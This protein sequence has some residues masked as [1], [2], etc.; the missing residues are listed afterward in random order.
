MPG[1]DRTSSGL[2]APRWGSR[3]APP[4]IISFANNRHFQEALAVAGVV[5]G[6]GM[7][8]SGVG[9]KLGDGWADGDAVKADVA[10]RRIQ[11][12]YGSRDRF[13]KL[14]R[15]NGIH[16]M[17]LRRDDNQESCSHLFRRLR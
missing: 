13:G 1:I 7:D 5:E 16:Q 6:F 4:T 11:D 8:G 2:N 10:A 12:N 15:W 9:E 17:I 3:A 14:S